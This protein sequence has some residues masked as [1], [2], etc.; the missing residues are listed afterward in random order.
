MQPASS[1][2]ALQNLRGENVREHR[3]ELQFKDDVVTDAA[4]LEK[5]GSEDPCY[6][7]SS[8]DE[9]CAQEV[10]ETCELEVKAD[11]VESLG[12][13]NLASPGSLS[14]RHLSRCQNSPVLFARIQVVL[15]FGR[16]SWLAS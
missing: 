11:L 12:L 7:S 5:K 6:F 3:V 1:S 15:N 10:S 8:L 4:C 9:L 2:A 13:R 14:D 16:C